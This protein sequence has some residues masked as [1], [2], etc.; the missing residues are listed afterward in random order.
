M[1]GLL[2]FVVILLANTVGAIS[3][4]G[5]G[6]LIKPIFDFIGYDS[7]SAVSF[8]STVAVFVMSIV[9]TWRQISNGNRL[10]ARMIIGVAS[11][12]VVGGIVGNTA[13]EVLLNAF[14]NNEILRLLQIV[15][16]IFTLVFAFLYTKYEW[17]QLQFIHLGWF[18]LCG[19]ILG[20]LSSF[21]GIGG[22]PINVTL[23]MLLFGLPIKEATVYSIGTIFFSQ[24]AK[25][26]TIATTTGFDRYD[27]GMLVFIIPAAILGGL[28]GAK[29]SQIL[30]AKKVAIIFQIVVLLV[31]LLNLYNGIQI[32]ALFSY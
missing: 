14:E 20:F 5:G 10:N 15:I 1:I 32:V 22:G 2:Y 17:K 28:I 21:L 27:L 11:G 16:T 26:V 30:P 8:Y 23:L 9:S 4:M 19:L 18:V 12:A 13:F 6:V 29:A 31:I 25:L 7:V 24:L 3:G